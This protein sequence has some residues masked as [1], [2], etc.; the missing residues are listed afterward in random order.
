[1]NCLDHAQEYVRRGFS[2][3]PLRLDGT[4]RSAVQWKKYQK[5]IATENEL[6]RWFGGEEL[7]HFR[8]G[9]ETFVLIGGEYLGM[10]I[11]P[12]ANGGM[13]LGTVSRVHT[14]DGCTEAP[15]DDRHNP[16]PQNPPPQEP[17]AISDQFFDY[18]HRTLEGGAQ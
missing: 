16:C 5:E 14:I 13:E 8:L 11:P 18:V 2:V 7:N 9:P 12:G 1:M 4:K 10:L 6:E 17:P 3:I 15:E